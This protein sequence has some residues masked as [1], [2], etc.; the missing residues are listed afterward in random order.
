VVHARVASL[1]IYWSSIRDEYGEDYARM[2]AA[3]GAGQRYGMVAS[4]S[5]ALRSD[6]RKT[7]VEVADILAD[8]GWSAEAIATLR[9]DNLI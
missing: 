3:S 6:A 7:F 5:K 8:W 4:A 2:A 9:R 1:S